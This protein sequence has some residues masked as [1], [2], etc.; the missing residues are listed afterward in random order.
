M[1][2]RGV[3]GETMSE[4]TSETESESSVEAKGG[5]GPG[6]LEKLSDVPMGNLPTHLEFQ[7]THVECKADAPIHTDTIQYSGAYATSGVDNSVRL[8][9][10]CDDFKVEVIRLTEEEMEFDMIGIDPALANA[11]RRIL[12]S[13]VSTMAIERVFIANNTSVVQD[14]VLAHRL[15]LIPIQVDPR[16]FEFAGN[17][18]PNEKNTIVFKLHVR[19]KQ[20][21]QRIAVKSNELK[22]SPNGSEFLLSSEDSK[23]AGSS[24][25]P[26][27]YTSFTCSQDSLS[28]FSN[29]A[30]SVM[31]NILIAKLG[32]GQEIELEA[33]A[34]KG[35]GKTHAKW[36]PVATAWYRMLPEVVLLEE[37]EDEAAEELKAKC[38]V[39]VFDIED[40]G[41]GKKRATVARPRACTLCR[42]CIR[43]GKQW[44]DR[45]SLR[46]LKNHFIFTIESTGSLPP[47]V[48]FTEAVKILE[49]KCERVIADL[50]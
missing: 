26:R 27:T 4:S 49:D 7:R 13:E 32:P 28:E 16:L 23:S 45:V 9:N 36:S 29:N 43:G 25:K 6:W 40:I 41:K 21:G 10:F 18:T 33:H 47:E 19:C 3:K 50:S 24:S 39:G 5:G 44:E 15:G 42:E 20:N 46:R 37:V 35:I 14:E 8:D 2:R 11:F 17:N 22:W 31:E 48:L 34:V 38:P 1:A 12:I 30:I